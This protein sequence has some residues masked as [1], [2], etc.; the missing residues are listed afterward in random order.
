MN[1]MHSAA[2]PFFLDTATGKRFCVLHAPRSAAECIGA[3][4]YLHP[5][6]EEMNMARRMA[7]LQA[8]A[9][10]AA[11]I[12]VLLVDL[13]GC[14]D[15]EGELKETSWEIWKQDVEAAAQWMRLR[16]SAPL[17]LWGLRLGAT[18]AIDYG[19]TAGARIASYLLWHPIIDGSQ[20]M[21][22]FLR[23]GA[24]AGML[25]TCDTAG[26]TKALRA[27]LA[28]GETIEVGGYELSPALVAGI[29]AASIASP[30]HIDAPVHWM[31]ILADEDAEVPATRL[32]AIQAWSDSGLDV[33][34]HTTCG[35]A[36]WSSTEVQEC[37]P[38]IRKS[39]VLFENAIA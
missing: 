16:F 13:H 28:R 37:C 5:F 34:L 10:A 9:F 36:F 33:H 32:R 20:A 26:D 23:L 25:G 38:L 11:G 19:R 29:E 39:S 27:A 12:A 3:V 15:S 14:G 22:Q 8:R 35:P 7:A 2:T 4:L 1:R 17:T 31:E 24:A 6:G 30:D 18:L 21:T